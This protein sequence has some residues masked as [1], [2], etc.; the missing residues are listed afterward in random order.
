MTRVAAAVLLVLGLAR[1]E[2]AVDRDGKVLRGPMA[3]EEGAVR[4]SERWSRPLAEFLLVEREDGGLVHAA[5]FAERVRAYEAIAADEV[6][7]RGAALAKEALA[8]HDPHAARRFLEAARR[9]GL[10]EREAQALAKR[11][12]T[13]ERGKLRAPAEEEAR[14][15]READALEAAVPALFL[16]RA[17]RAR[18]EGDVALRLLA[19]ALRR[20]PAHAPSL[21]WLAELAPKEFPLGDARAWLRFHL[22]LEPEGFRLVAEEDFD[23]KRARHHWRPDLFALANDSLRLVTAVR[24]FDAVEKCLRRAALVCTALEEI[25]A[26]GAPRRQDRKPL[27]LFLHADRDEYRKH[28]GDYSRSR[29]VAFLDNPGGH[30]SAVDNLSRFFLPADP[31][32]E[33]KFLRWLAGRVADHWMYARNPR[34]TFSDA[35]RSYDAAGAWVAYGFARM[36]QE[37]GADPATGRW[38]LLDPKSETLDA[39]H[40]MFAEPSNQLIPWSTLFLLN[41]RDLDAL[42]DVPIK[43]VRRYDPGVKWTY[44]QGAAYVARAGAVCLTLFHAGDGRLRGKL[45][46]YVENHF[47]GEGAKMN[48][49]VAFGMSPDALGDLTLAFAR[50]VLFK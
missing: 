45:V 9:A 29:D 12:E 23:L 17:R 4:L 21:E 3:I 47:R 32:E 50:Q 49:Q 41:G 33:S 24:D 44:S 13:V 27:E 18:E 30:Y 15:R 7:T 42:P 14:F 48:P 1:A 43:L 25:F 11:I 6:R 8:A 22:A 34:F 35:V 31:A 36:M 46:E 10:A 39:V 5:G 37:I 16:A 2:V 26:T 40:G 20:D 19:E 28:A 38:T